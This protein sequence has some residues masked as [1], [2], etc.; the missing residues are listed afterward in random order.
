MPI[1]LFLHEIYKEEL[2]NYLKW[3]EN[4]RIH[5]NDDVYWWMTDLAGRNNLESNF[6]LYICQIKSLK[7]ILKNIEENE[8]L[9]VCDDILLIQ[10]VKENLIANTTYFLFFLFFASE[11][12]VVKI[13]ALLISPC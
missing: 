8:V 2:P 9:I 12:E 1:S 4:Q 10:A 13:A 6:F 5:F 11:H 3:T 7:K